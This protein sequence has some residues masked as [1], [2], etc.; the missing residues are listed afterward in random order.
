DL[1]RDNIE[2]DPK[3]IDTAIRILSELHEAW[4]E[5]A[6]IVKRET[7][8]PRQNAD[9]GPPLDV[10]HQTVRTVHATV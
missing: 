4:V 5:A 10:E 8:P 1:A 2:K 9:A 3:P 7:H 6:K